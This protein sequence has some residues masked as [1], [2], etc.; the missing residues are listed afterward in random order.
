[1]S[2]HLY[3]HN[4]EERK[5]N[6]RHLNR[7]QL[8]RMAEDLKILNRRDSHLLST[9]EL[10]LNNNKEMNIENIFKHVNSYNEANAKIE[11]KEE[12]SVD[13]DELLDKM[14]KQIEVIQKDKERLVK[15]LEEA[16]AEEQS[17]LANRKAQEQ[18]EAISKALNIPS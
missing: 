1:M 13:R 6:L 14:M 11:V 9:H 5:S 7:S 12:I 18:L 2:R 17:E 8:L 10:R 3:N 15:Q 16:E 4:T